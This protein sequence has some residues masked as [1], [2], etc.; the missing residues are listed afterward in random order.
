[1]LSLLYVLIGAKHADFSTISRFVN[2][3]ML[4]DEGFMELGFQLLTSRCLNVK[5]GKGTSNV[6]EQGPESK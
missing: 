3:L 1:M 5:H 4:P 6:K 2:L